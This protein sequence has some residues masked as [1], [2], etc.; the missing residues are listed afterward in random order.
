MNKQELE[1]YLKRAFI[2]GETYWMQ[3]NS[4]SYSE[5]K[6]ADLTWRRF[7]DMLHEAINKLED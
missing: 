6:K 3:A 5:N 2:L 1:A 7:Q 4:E